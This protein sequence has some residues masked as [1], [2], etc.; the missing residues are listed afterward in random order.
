MITDNIANVN[1]YNNLGDRFQRAFTYLRETDLAQ[2]PVGRIELDGK[3]LYVLI[4]EYSTKLPGTGKW[5][6][7]KR[8]IDIQFIVSGQ[9][10][11]GYA[12]LKRLQQGIY[13]P[14]KDF[15]PLSGDGDW[16]TVSAGDFMVLWPNDGHMPGMAID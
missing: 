10:R 2:L 13:D 9:E 5:E 8:Y 1:L 12:M 7:H 4:Q 6:A 3:N 15:L 14:V 16:V 11:I